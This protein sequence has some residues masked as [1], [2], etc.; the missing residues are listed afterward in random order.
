MKL[1][2]SCLKS[3]FDVDTPLKHYTG[4][5]LDISHQCALVVWRLKGFS[6]L[7]CLELNLTEKNSRTIVVEIRIHSLHLP[8]CQMAFFK[9]AWQKV[10]VLS[11]P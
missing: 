1:L 6:V 4:L 9:W 11:R 10:K 5:E 2:E 7:L 3:N 8:L